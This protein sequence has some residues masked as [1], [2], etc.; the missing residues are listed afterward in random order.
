MIVCVVAF[1]SKLL[2]STV[3]F[4]TFTTFTIMLFGNTLIASSIILFTLLNKLD[5]VLITCILIQPTFFIYIL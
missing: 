4:F 5:V 1:K 3:F 2:T